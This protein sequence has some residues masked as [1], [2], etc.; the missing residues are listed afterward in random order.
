[1][2]KVKTA[3]GSYTLY[4]EKYGEIYHSVTGAEEEA[5]KKYVE[6]T[7]IFELAKSGELR[8]LDVCFGLGYNSAAAIDAALKSNPKCK[9]KIVGLELDEKLPEFFREL[10]P[11]FES[12][13]LIRQIADGKYS[14]K[15]VDIR[16][17][18][19]DA[20][21]KI[22]EVQGEFDACFFD[23][24]SPKTQPEMWEDTFFKDVGEK[25]R[26]GAKLATYSCA[27]HVRIGL[28]RAGFDAKDGPCIGRRA[29]STIAVKL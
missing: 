19:G 17:I 23:P 9:I 5:V 12:Y 14:G 6:P 10:E 24:F 11:S 16:I 20:K 22:K 8:I 18:F 26:R 3:D 27:T 4:N 25:L 21:E 1:M 28:V 7:G 29:P 2:K 15:N 13:K